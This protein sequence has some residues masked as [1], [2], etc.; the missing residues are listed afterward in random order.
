MRCTPL[1][2]DK[3]ISLADK[4][5]DAFSKISGLHIQGLTFS[6]LVG[7]EIKAPGVGCRSELRRASRAGA[8]K[9]IQDTGALLAPAPTKDFYDF[10]KYCFE[11]CVFLLVNVLQGLTISVP[12]LSYPVFS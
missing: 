12:K 5:L 6:Y 1:A 9:G 11:F 4:G 7:V 10:C 8:Q 2:S 3:N